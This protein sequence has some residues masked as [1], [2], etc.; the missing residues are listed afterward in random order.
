MRYDHK[1]LTSRILRDVNDGIIAIDHAGNILFTNP[2]FYEILGIEENVNGSKYASLM[3]ND[4]KNND[5]FHQ[6]LLQSIEDKETTHEGK[7]TYTRKDGK[8][9]TL[10]VSS[11]TSLPKNC[12]PR[13]TTIPPFRLSFFWQGSVSGSFCMAYGCIWDSRCM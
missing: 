10:K 13:S 9:I 5:D 11:S 6:M 12:T 2:R 3:M 7:V 8:V 4:S 1:K